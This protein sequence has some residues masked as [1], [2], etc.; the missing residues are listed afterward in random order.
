MA[1]A[2]LAA[3]EGASRTEQAAIAADGP[4]AKRARVEK[5]SKKD[6]KAKEKKIKEEQ[7]RVQKTHVLTGCERVLRAARSPKTAEELL[8]AGTD[9]GYFYL[10]GT[11]ADKN[12]SKVLQEDIK[13]GS[14]AAF[15]FQGGKFLLA[16][17][18]L[19]D[20]QQAA[21]VQSRTTFLSSLPP[22]AAPATPEQAKLVRCFFVLAGLAKAQYHN[23]FA[24][25]VD[26]VALGLLDYHDVIKEPMDTGTVKQKLIDEQYA[27]VADF[28]RDLALVWSNAMTYN[29][30]HDLVHGWAKSFDALTLKLYGDLGL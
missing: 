8:F 6:L 26:A 27:T 24:E 19:P 9:A 17:W 30:P 12:V 5:V 21:H 14:H 11:G 4:P 16:E 13:N 2:L 1:R 10:K 28:K 15:V 18:S 3:D 29:P 7:M 25:P 23:V 22:F 20:E